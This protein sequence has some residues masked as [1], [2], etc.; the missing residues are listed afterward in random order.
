MY[1]NSNKNMNVRPEA[2]KLLEE[3]IVSKLLEIGLSNVF[4]NLASKA[5]QQNQKPNTWD[6][7]KIKI[8]R[9]PG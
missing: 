5:R 8:F 2:I 1:L 4:P 7:I 3:N 6:Y 9:Q